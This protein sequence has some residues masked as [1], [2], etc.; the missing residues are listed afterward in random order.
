MAGITSEDF[1]ILSIE[2]AGFLLKQS[3]FLPELFQM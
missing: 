3:H 1:D 2:L